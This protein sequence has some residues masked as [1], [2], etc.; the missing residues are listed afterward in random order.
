MYKNILILPDGTELKSGTGTTNAIRSVKLSEMV[1]NGTDLMP[2]SCCSDMIEASIFTPGGALEITAG[3]EI[4]LWK[5]SQDGQRAQMGVYTVEAPTR[6]TANTMKVAGYDHAAKLDKDLT[7]W[8]G[9]LTGWPYSINDFAA[10]VCQACGLTFSPTNGFPNEDFQIR[11]WSKS[12]VTGRQI[13]RWLGE[14]VCRFVHADPQGNICFGWYED[15]GKC[16]APKGEDYYFAGSFSY[17]NYQVAPVDVVQLRL[18]DS[19]AGALWPEAEEG[20]NAYIITGNAILTANVTGDLLPVLEA[21]QAELSAVTYTPCTVSGLSDPAIRAGSII[22]IQDKNGNQVR[23]YVMEKASSGQRDTFTCTGNPRRDSTTAMNNKT[24]SEKSAEAAANAAA[25]LSQKDI[26]NKLTNNG[27]DQGI[28]LQD[29]KLYVNLEYLKAGSFTST[30]E[31]FL[32]PG[33]EEAETIRQHLLGASVIPE[34]DLRKYD[35]NSDGDVTITDALI[36]QKCALGMQTLR[37]WENAVKTPVTVTVDASNTGKVIWIHGTNMW[38]RAVDYYL[39][40]AGANLG[41]ILGNLVVSGNLTVGGAVRFGTNANGEP[42]LALGN[43]GIPKS[44]SWKDN[45][46]GTFSLIGT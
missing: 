45:G 16:F 10:M 15:S 18:A 40:F 11:Q 17:E 34:A 32:D 20:A 44:I 19:Q 9:Q 5:E 4:S 22:S 46:D 24:E 23:A 28:F 38:G 31:V 27:E 43:T 42:T 37:E 13:M 21:I 12:G 6:P 7:A 30:A 26:F 14:I 2:G 36:A 8:L 33:F 1:N 25:G 29:G 41:R 35:F 39:G 3:D